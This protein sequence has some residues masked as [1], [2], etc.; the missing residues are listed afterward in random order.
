MG[1][2]FVLLCSFCNL[3]LVQ[4]IGHSKQSLRG[5]SKEE[6]D[7]L[8]S[9]PSEAEFEEE[10]SCEKCSTSVSQ[11]HSVVISLIG[12]NPASVAS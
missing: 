7:D 5:F 11:V 10:I 6:T 8:Y 4:E 3:I 12:V 9:T 1:L 2:F